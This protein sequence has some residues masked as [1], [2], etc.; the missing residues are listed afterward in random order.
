MSGENVFEIQNHSY[1]LHNLNKRKGILKQKR[2]TEQQYEKMLIS[3][4]DKNQKLLELN[5]GITPNA[6]T[7]PFGAVNE[8]ALNVIKS[9]GFKVTY[10]C[11]EGVNY[12]TREPE[13]LYELKRYNRT[14]NFDIS[15]IL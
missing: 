4:I 7:C 10:G 13:C 14:K 8:K 12:I 1:N 9:M 5:C 3:D 15:Q 6:F 11:E 2:E